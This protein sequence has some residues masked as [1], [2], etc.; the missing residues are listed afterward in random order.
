MTGASGVR[1]TLGD[2]SSYEARVVGFDQDKDVA[3]L[4]LVDNERGMPS[5]AK[6]RPL[7]LGSS[8]AL[9]VG[10]RV[11]A[12]GNPFVWL[13]WGRFDVPERPQVSPSELIESA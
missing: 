4:K 1:V 6:L 7:P 12:I 5:T 11:Y 3:V 13:W 8:R 10:Q 2:S 9:Q